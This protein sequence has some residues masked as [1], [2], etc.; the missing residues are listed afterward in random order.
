[1]AERRNREPH[2]MLLTGSTGKIGAPTA[3]ALEQAGYMVVGF[4]ADAGDDVRDSA[5]LDERMRGCAA[6]AH[7]AAIPDDDLA[8]PHEIIDTNVFGTW[9]VLA[10]A[11]RTGVDRVVVF[12]SIQAT[13]LYAGE[14]RA[15]D[16]LPLD[17]DHATYAL[18]P[19]SVSKLV[20]EEMCRAFSNAT[21][22]P[23]VCLR[24]PFVVAEEEIADLRQQFSRQEKAD[25]RERTWCH[26]RDVAD[27]VVCALRA[28]TSG[29][30]VL[31]L[32]ADDVA[33]YTP[34]VELAQAA[35]APW[36]GADDRFA[37]LVDA[38]RAKDVLGWRPRYRWPR[39]ER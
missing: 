25:W 14:G 4:D 9:A 3:E 23:T 16:Y 7:L 26:V 8:P 36:H 37:S 32:S 35:G 29:S 2:R 31:F 28:D 5:A 20:G 6:V 18:S 38:S 33:G 11:E 30:V 17:E 27:A 10:A 1:M 19:Y 15:P 22:I 34:A 13:G 24:P 12:S 39:E 21:G